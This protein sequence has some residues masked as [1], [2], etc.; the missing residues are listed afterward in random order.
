MK[1]STSEGGALG[2]RDV[3]PKGSKGGSG[4][5][6]ADQGRCRCKG[7]GGLG[8]QLQGGTVLRQ[9]PPPA[10]PAGDVPLRPACRPAPLSS[11]QRRLGFPSLAHLKPAPQPMQCTA[12]GARTLLLPAMSMP[13]WC[14]LAPHPPP[15]PSLPPGAAPF[16]FLLRCPL[17][18]PTTH[19]RSSASPKCTTQTS[20][21]R[22]VG[23]AQRG[24]CRARGI[25]WLLCPAVSCERVGGKR[26]GAGGWPGVGV[27]GHCCLTCHRRLPPFSGLP[28]SPAPLADGTRSAPAAGQ[29]LPQHPEG[30]LEA[31]A[32]YHS[33]GVRPQ[34]PVPGERHARHRAGSAGRTAPPRKRAWQRAAR[35]GLFL[36]ARYGLLGAC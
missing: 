6:P 31:G 21:W 25:G 18:T 4:C 29:H 9:P 20:I 17:A 10:K 28:L 36:H 33:G 35:A 14:S 15:L 5:K 27:T 2:L 26:V 34:L 32:D 24:R 7:T 8:R 3:R 1:G 23:A 22:W 16:C 11:G 13:S 30:G 12:P 19:P